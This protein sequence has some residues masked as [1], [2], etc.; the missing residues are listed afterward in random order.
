MT[1][2]LLV[3]GPSGSVTSFEVQEESWARIPGREIESGY[4][5]SVR[6]G[7]SDATWS[8]VGS[9][10]ELLHGGAPVPGSR[11][12]PA[13]FLAPRLTHYAN[14]SPDG[15]RLCYVVPDGQSLVLKVWTYGE[16]DARTLTAGAPLFPAWDASGDALFV[17]NGSS[18]QVFELVSGEQRTLS[19]AAAGFRTPAVN[20]KSG[21]IAWA[22]VRDGAVEVM[23]GTRRGVA[24]RVARFSSGVTLAFRPGT[25]ELT[26]AVAT[27]PESSVFGDLCTAA[28][29]S[30]LKGPFVSYWWAPDGSKVLALYP[31]YTGD[32]RFQPRLFDA[33]GNFL[34]AVEPFIPAP[35][36]ATAVGFYDQYGLSH[37]FWSSDS[38]WFGMAGRFLTEGPPASFGG[39]DA[40]QAWVWDTVSG[41]IERRLAPGSMLAF[42]RD[43]VN[44]G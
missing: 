39:G 25:D 37:P 5:A 30:L 34:R 12:E 19:D 28:G 18:L 16:S 33:E 23:Q 13:L 3:T 29:R 4:W 10:A 20:K 2:T 35:D 26:V 14:W 6:P 8:S 43:A 22:D 24:E 41:A 38:R 1:P 32:G 7:T 17:H 27:S 31:S 21:L 11:T 9:A 15:R 36:T 44:G 42:G 40:D